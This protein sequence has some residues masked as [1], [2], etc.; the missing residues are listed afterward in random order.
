MNAAK[1]LAALAAGS[2]QSK[3]AICTADA[4]PVLVSLLKSDSS[5]VHHLAA[6]VLGEL[7]DG[8]QQSKD[9]IVA[10]ALVSLLKSDGE[11]SIETQSEAVRALAQLAA[12]SQHNNDAIIAADALPALVSLLKVDNI[13]I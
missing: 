3:D 12:G 4:L 2:Q 5:F 13:K 1:A 10:E 11:W 6:Q 7:A 8:S 9:A